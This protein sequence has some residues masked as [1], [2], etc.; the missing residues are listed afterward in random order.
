MQGVRRAMKL[1]SFPSSITSI[2]ACEAASSAGAVSQV[3]GPNLKHQSPVSEVPNWFQ[4]NHL[5]TPY[6]SDIFCPFIREP[7]ESKFPAFDSD[8]VPIRKV[9]LIH[10]QADLLITASREMN[11]V[12]R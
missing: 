12:L 2:S 6:T 7:P 4:P 3:E 9:T 5:E 1:Y 10:H 11:S 8:P